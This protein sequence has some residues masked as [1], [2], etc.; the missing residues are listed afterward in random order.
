MKT[1]HAPPVAVDAGSLCLPLSA[2]PAL[3]K[4][5]MKKSQHAWVGVATLAAGLGAVGCLATMLMAVNF[6]AAVVDNPLLALHRADVSTPL[7]KASML[8]DLFGYYLLLL[9]LVFLLRQWAGAHRLTAQVGSFCGTAYALVGAV[10]AAVLATAWPAV[11]EAHRAAAPQAKEA[12]ATDFRLLYGVVNDGLWNL[13]EMLF[14]A[15][16]WGWAGAVL[17]KKGFRKTGLLSS[18]LALACVGDAASVMTDARALHS[19]SLNAYLVLSIAWTVVMGVLVLRGKF[20]S[21]SALAETRK[22]G[23]RYASALAVSPR[24]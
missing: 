24:G 7:L 10:G 21:V 22:A 9:P 17:R 1:V 2:A 15:V 13:L 19:L 6:D 12:L 18:A 8:F 14:A 16:W 20:D 23:L 4:K 11:L 3:R 5:R